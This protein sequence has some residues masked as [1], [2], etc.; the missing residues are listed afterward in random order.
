MRV[1]ATV[2][3]KGQ[4]TLPKAVR[5]RHNLQ[6]GDQVEFVEENGRT[7]VRAKRLQAVD[8]IGILGPSPVGARLAGEE[9]DQAI[10]DAAA[11]AAAEDDE[12]IMREWRERSQ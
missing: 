12:R 4:V 11:E 10:N 8:L 9:L 2:T 7:W 6:P 5:E 1:L 3:S